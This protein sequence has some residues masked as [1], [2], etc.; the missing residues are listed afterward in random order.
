ML[1]DLL[2]LVVTNRYR[3]TDCLIPHRLYLT[4]FPQWVEIKHIDLF[5]R[6]IDKEKLM[7]SVLHVNLRDSETDMLRH[8]VDEFHLNHSPDLFALIAENKLGN[9][10]VTHI[11]WTVNFCAELPDLSDA[12]RLVASHDPRFDESKISAGILEDS[13]AG[14]ARSSMPSHLHWLVL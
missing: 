4:L 2:W 6:T 12:L 13:E 7:P 1:F 11:S 14:A 10:L 9:L 3:T 8:L 5:L